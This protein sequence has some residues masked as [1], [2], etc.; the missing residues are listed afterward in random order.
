MAEQYQGDL[1][2]S[3]NHTVERVCSPQ[4]Y[5]ALVVSVPA[6]ECPGTLLTAST[7]IGNMAREAG[8][9]FLPQGSRITRS[10][11]ITKETATNGIR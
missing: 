10:I 6:A 3:L 1:I 2:S 9:T 5:F 8:P 11:E 4:R 7:E